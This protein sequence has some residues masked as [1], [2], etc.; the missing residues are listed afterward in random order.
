[1]ISSA[2]KAFIQYTFL[3]AMLVTLGLVGM[4]LLLAKAGKRIIDNMYVAKDKAIS[5]RIDVD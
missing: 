5:G 2:F 3:N 4:T 1:M